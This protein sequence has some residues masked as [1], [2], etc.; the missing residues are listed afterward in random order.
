[1]RRTY[2]PLF[3]EGLRPKRGTEDRF[4]LLVGCILVNRTQWNQARP[5][6]AKLRRE[7]PMQLDLLSQHTRRVREIVSPLGLSVKRAENIVLLARTFDR[8]FDYGA[9]PGWARIED[10][11]GCGKYAADSWAIFVL[12]RRPAGVTDVRLLEYLEHTAM[13]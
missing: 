13:G 3:Q 10:L 5:V 2:V 8:R 11:P 9:E 4:W 6:M 1:V 12:G 7:F